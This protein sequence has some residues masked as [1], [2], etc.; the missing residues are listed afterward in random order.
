MLRIVTDSSAGLPHDLVERY[1]IEVVPLNVHFGRTS[2][3]DGVDMGSAQFY[4]MLAQAKE[5]PTTSQPSPGQFHEVY[6]RLTANGDQVLSIHISGQ[7]SGTI[8]SAMSA[9]DMLPEAEIAVIDSLS[10]SMGQGLIVLAAAEAVQEGRSHEDVAS[11][12]EK[13]ICGTHVVFIVDTLEYLQRGGRIGG[14]AAFLG[15]L[16]SLKPLLEIRN[17]HVEPLERVRTRRKAVRRAM[18]VLRERFDGQGRLR[19]FVIHA[20]CSEEAN[21]LAQSMRDLLPRTSVRVAEISPVLGIH[22]GPGT[23]GVGGCAEE[24]LQ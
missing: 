2:Y 17:G 21:R 16:L 7:L 6:S 4:R 20:E 24:L 3:Q 8:Q 22:G 23:L 10:V 13:A 19:L 9:R 11:L 12:V 18:E 14:A 1:N 5:L 15:T